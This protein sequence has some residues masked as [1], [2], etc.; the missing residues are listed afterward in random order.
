LLASDE[1]K[2]REIEADEIKPSNVRGAAELTIYWQKPPSSEIM[3]GFKRLYF[4]TGKTLFTPAEMQTQDWRLALNEYM[5]QFSA[6]KKGD[7]ESVEEHFHQKCILFESLLFDL[8]PWPERD[9]VVIDFLDFL[10]DFNMRQGSR[11]EWFWHANRLVE[12]LNRT[13]GAETKTELMWQ[14][15]SMKNHELYLYSQ[16]RKTLSGGV[17]TEL[18]SKKRAEI[19]NIKQ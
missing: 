7:K 11:I 12:K 13:Q 8:S 17:K 2:V 10:N 4:R 16:L 5:K 19:E 15:M 1:R 9:A 6:W 14:L 18:P 3:Q